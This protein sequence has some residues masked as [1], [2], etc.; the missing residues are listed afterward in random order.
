VLA[1][2]PR[3]SQNHEKQLETGSVIHRFP[4]VSRDFDQPAA[5]LA[6]VGS[7]RQLAATIRNISDEKKRKILISSDTRC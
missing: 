1:K 7:T 2:T 3:T 4:V 6:A 5:I